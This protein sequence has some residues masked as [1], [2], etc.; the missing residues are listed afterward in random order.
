VVQIV[1]K[2][3][4]KNFGYVQKKPGSQITTGHPAHENQKKHPLSQLLLL[5]SDL[6]AGAQ[7][8]GVGLFK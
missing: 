1:Q 2:S 4:L 3:Y 6:E 8:T 7:Y 5:L